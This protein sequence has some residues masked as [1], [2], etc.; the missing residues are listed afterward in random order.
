MTQEG[1]TMQRGG[2]DY[3]AVP[4]VDD[5]GAGNW[6]GGCAFEDADADCYPCGDMQWRHKKQNGGGGEMTFTTLEEFTAWAID[7][8]AC[9][10]SIAKLRACNTFADVEAGMLLSY[11]VWCAERGAMQFVEGLDFS[12]LNGFGVVYLL[13]AQPQLADRCDFSKIAGRDMSRLFR[14]QPQ[15]AKYI[16]DAMTKKTEDAKCR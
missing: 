9:G 6:C 1:D 5:E 13:R 7:K 10:G 16:E 3:V 11:A 12:R 8:G 15:L 4:D 14:W 2:V